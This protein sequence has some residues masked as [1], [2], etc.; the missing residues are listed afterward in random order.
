MSGRGKYHF[1]FTAIPEITSMLTT[2][3]DGDG[4]LT[5]VRLKTL[6]Q[7]VISWHP[8]N[9]IMQYQDYSKSGLFEQTPRTFRSAVQPSDDKN[10]MANTWPVR[11]VPKTTNALAYWSATIMSRG[12]YD[13]EGYQ[14][15]TAISGSTNLQVIMMKHIT[16]IKEKFL[17][18][19][20]G[21]VLPDD[22][23][24]LVEMKDGNFGDPLKGEDNV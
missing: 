10:K 24:D 5:N 6:S 19:R 2:F 13:T 16:Y 1:G 14:R 12:K 23:V 8:A 22:T 20:I 3:L 17:K 7:Y 9:Y 4:K 18:Q 21:E 15:L 11:V